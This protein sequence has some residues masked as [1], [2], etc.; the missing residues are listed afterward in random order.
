MLP[1]IEAQRELANITAVSAAFGSMKAADRQRYVGRL[2]RLAVGAS[3]QA[4]VPTPEMLAAMGVAVVIVP[5]EAP[6]V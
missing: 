6:G 2:T 5:P 4:P 1:R 3:A